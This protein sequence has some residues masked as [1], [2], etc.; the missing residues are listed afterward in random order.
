MA[1]RNPAGANC[2]QY[3]TVCLPVNPEAPYRTKS[4]LRSVTGELNTVKESKR[5]ALAVVPRRGLE[6]PRIAPLVP[7]TSASTSSATWARWVRLTRGAEMY[8][9]GWWLSIVGPRRRR[10]VAGNMLDLSRQRAKWANEREE[11]HRATR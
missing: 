8:A 2:L 11:K 3:S 4:Y 5:G 9:L 7:E 10:R 6:P 1:Q